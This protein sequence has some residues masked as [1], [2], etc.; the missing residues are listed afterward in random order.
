MKKRRMFIGASAL[1]LTLFLAGCSNN[2]KAQE[3]AGEV[4][5]NASDVSKTG[6]PIVKEPLKLTMFAPASGENDFSKMAMLNEYG[7]M[8]GITFDFTTPPVDDVAT[9]L[10]LSFASGD[11]PGVIFAAK[12]SNATTIQYGGSTILP[13]EKYIEEG[14]MPNF[15][16]ILDEF[17]EVRK[18]V[19]TPDGHIYTLPLLSSKY[20]LEDKEF[21][22]QQPLF[23]G[24]LWW[25][26]E[27]LKKLNLE[28]PKTTD[29]LYTVLKA[30]KEKDPNGNGKADEIPMTSAKLESLRPWLMNAFGVMSQEQQVD[31]E[32]KVFYGAITDNYR[33]YLKFVNKL[34]AEGLLD[35]EVFSQSDDQKKSKGAADR[36]GAYTDWFSYF[37]SGKNPADAINDP[38][39]Y[40]MSS[41]VSPTATFNMSDGISNGAFALTNK[42][43]NPAAALRWVD[44][45][46]SNEGSQFLNIGPDE[47]KGGYWH[48]EKNDA[49]EEV[50]VLNKGIKYEDSEQA[51]AK[52]TPD[53]GT[54][55]PKVSSA[56]VLVL[57]DKNTPIE[58][59][60]FAKFIDDQATEKLAPFVH[61]SWP[62]LYMSKAQQDE[63]GSTLQAD[64]LTYVQQ[65]EAKFITGTEKL[66]DTT[67]DTYVKTLKDIG[68]DKF[69]DVNQ[70]AYDTWNEA[71]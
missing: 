28:V 21:A 1:L 22:S 46:Y 60:T 45:F 71:K 14:Y 51:R 66:D 49:G 41:P 8:S 34:Y 70:K 25:N 68:L 56:S 52:V 26:G 6:F 44:Y 67:W 59:D 55:P 18:S 65:M 63:L 11:A 23:T 40:P 37:T 30:F 62:T 69:V 3:N 5:K 12:I 7:N 4:L 61:T 53:Y 27:W 32:G 38:M 43:E 33:E 35:N 17:P 29:E 54:V 19:T 15:K 9:K 2:D 47:S 50:H 48:L 57:P 64:L 58:K 20:N 10:N 16:K 24:S 31:K 39:A 36:L 13:I 42:V